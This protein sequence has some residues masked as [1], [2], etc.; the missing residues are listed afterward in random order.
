[1]T[2]F[3]KSICFEELLVTPFQA[4]WFVGL[5]PTTKTN[6]VNASNLMQNSTSGGKSL[7]GIQNGTGGCILSE[8]YQNV[9]TT[10]VSKSGVIDLVKSK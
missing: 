9:E 4:A 10:L 2:T 6:L 8:R 3:I 5:I 1:M 7:P